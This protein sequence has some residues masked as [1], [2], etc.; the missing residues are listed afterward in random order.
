LLEKNGVKIA[1]ISYVSQEVLAAFAQKH[2]IGYPL[3]SDGGSLVIRSFGIFN[4]NMAPELKAYGVPHPVDYLIS[5]DGVVV[6]KYF[7][8]NYQ[9]RVTASAVALQE[10]SEVSSDA[11]EITLES[12]ALRVRVG[13][14]S[15]TAFAG[16]EVRFFARFTLRPGWRIYGSPLP[17]RYTATSMEFEGPAIKRHDIAWPEPEM[18]EFPV[19]KEML[20]AYSSAFEIQ[21]TL[22][23][24]FSLPEGELILPGRLRFQLCSERHM[25]AL[26][27]HCL[28]SSAHT[29]TFCRFRT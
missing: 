7:V 28:Y 14:P 1:A 23:L 22:L 27:Y 8:P 4:F 20:P 25:R 16:Q 2:S 5:P 15:R 29:S 26:A 17:E 18:V 10:F 13:L 11:T 12:E 24:K 6:R 21:G 19:L 3:L 9:H